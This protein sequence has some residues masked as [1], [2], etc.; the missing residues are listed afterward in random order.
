[1]RSAALIYNPKSGRQR[2]ARVLDD[3]L[4]TLRRG[5]FAVEPAP[6]SCAG[7]ATVLARDLAKAGNTEVVFSFGGDGTAREVAAGLLGSPVALGFLPGGTAN[8]LALGFGL[9]PDPVRAAAALCT[10]TAR[11]FDVGLAEQAG[12]GRGIPFLMMV[13]AGLDATILAALDLRLKY[14]FGKGAIVWQGLRE[15]WRYPYPDLEIVA[16][17]ERHTATFA[18]V[19]NIP[20]YGGSFRLAP[21]ARPD[22]RLLE[23]VLFHGRGRRATISFALDL[24]RGAHLRRRD[25]TVLRVEEVVLA[26]PPGGAAQI[27]GDLCDDRLP[28]SIKLAPERLRALFPAPRGT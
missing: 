12:S 7:E 9:P 20:Y 27:D 28:L 3:I 17:G 5:G 26:G 23:L 11:D 8:L 13:S 4:A 16:G 21:D 2:H 25:V 18:A 15:W 19:A 24:L 1:L 6:T 10:A 22:N 14:R